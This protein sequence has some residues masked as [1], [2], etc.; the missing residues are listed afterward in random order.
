MTRVQDDEISERLLMVTEAPLRPPGHNTTAGGTTTTTL[1]RSHTLTHNPSTSP[2][3]SPFPPHPHSLPQT[4]LYPHT[5]IIT[6][7][8]LTS[9][10]TTIQMRRLPYWSRA[11]LCTTGAPRT[12]NP[13]RGFPLC[14]H[15]LCVGWVGVGSARLQNPPPPTPSATPPLGYDGSLQDTPGSPATLRQEAK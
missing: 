5:L 6:L 1:K 11:S 2:T 9:G 15:A 3:N 13:P 8:T 4:H 14:T 7:L 12:H 10:G